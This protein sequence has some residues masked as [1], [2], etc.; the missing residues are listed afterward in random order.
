MNRLKNNGWLFLEFISIEEKDIYQNDSLA[1]SFAILKCK[2]KYLFCYNKW[3]QQWELP[4]GRREKG[5]TPKQCAIRELYEETGQIVTDLEFKGLLKIKNIRDERL[6]YNPVYYTNIEE[7]QPFVENDETVAI[8]LW[9]LHEE[10][11]NI[12][13]V[14]RQIVE[15][16]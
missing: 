14:D 13:E 16:F 7:L 5:E 10:I 11:G 4:A 3:R 1:G 12:D 9:D 2:D 6:K 8:K 15:Y